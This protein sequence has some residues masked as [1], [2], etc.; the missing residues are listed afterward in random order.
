[1][2]GKIEIV[3]NFKGIQISWSISFGFQALFVI[4][5]IVVNNLHVTKQVFVVLIA[6]V[7]ANEDV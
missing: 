6:F 7:L 3:V 2:S 1:M 5:V 4:V